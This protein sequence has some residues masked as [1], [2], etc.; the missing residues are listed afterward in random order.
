MNEENN[1]AEATN[2][3][4][5]LTQSGLKP[6]IVPWE[7]YRGL[8]TKITVQLKNVEEF[9]KEFDEAGAVVKSRDERNN[10]YTPLK[11]VEDALTKWETYLEQHGAHQ[12][13]MKKQNKDYVDEEFTKQLAAYQTND[14][15][16]NYFFIKL[17]RLCSQ[18]NEAQQEFRQRLG[19]A[20]R[21]EPE[22][23]TQQRQIVVVQDD[24]TRLNHGLR[25]D[26]LSDNA[27]V[28]QFEGWKRD[29]KS[30]FTINAMDKKSTDVQISALY[31][32]LDE[33]L[34]RY[35]DIHFAAL[36]SV[37]IV[38]DEPHS[39]LQALIHYFDSKHP[40]P[41]RVLNFFNERQRPNES[42]AEFA[43]RCEALA[44]SANIEKMTPDCW[45][46]H[47]IATGLVHSEQLRNKLL[48]KLTNPKYKSYD[49][50]KDIEEETAT[51]KVT[52]AIDRQVNASQVNQLSDYKRQI[53]SNRSNNYQKQQWQSGGLQPRIPS[54]P[55]PRLSNA[56]PPWMRPTSRACHQC[57]YTPFFECREHFR[58]RPRTPAPFQSRG[59]PNI[60]TLREAEEDEEGESQFSNTLNTVTNIP[61]ACAA[62]TA[63]FERNE[64]GNPIMPTGKQ[65]PLLYAFIREK[66]SHESLPS[67]PNSHVTEVLCLAD[68]GCVRS[69]CHPSM[70][71]KCGLRINHND[72]TKM[73]AANGTR[74]N[75]IG[76]VTAQVSY[77]GIHTDLKIFIMQDVSPNYIILDREVCQVLNIFH[78]DFPLPL[79]TIPQ[80]KTESEPFGGKFRENSH[81]QLTLDNRDMNLS[82]RKEPKSEEKVSTEKT[83][84]NES[85]C[86][87]SETKV[88]IT[89]SFNDKS[90]EDE[91]LNKLNKLIECY[92]PVFDI[93]I[94]KEIKCH[95]VRLRFRQD[96]P[97]T[98]YK[99]TSSRP[100]PFALREAARKEVEEQIKLGIIARVPPNVHLEWCSRGMV[101]AKDNARDCRIVCDNVELNK[102]LDRNAFPIQSP[103]ELVKQ[104]PTT[105]K[106]FLSCDFYKGFFQIP[107]AVEDQHK[108]AFMLHSIGILYYKR[109]MQG[110]KTSVDEFNRITDELVQEV[111]NCLKMVDD[112]L[113]HGPTIDDVLTQFKCLLEKCHQRNFT[114]HPKKLKF[115]NRL[116]FAGYRV[117]DKGL[118]IDPKKVNAI[119]KFSKP[120][121]VTDMKSFLGLAAQFQEACPDLLGILKPLSDATSF[122]ITPGF[123]E[124]GKKIKNHKRAIVWSKP[125]EEAFVKAKQALTDADGRVLAP[126][127]PALPLIIYTDAS[128]L[129]GLGWVALQEREGIKR[130]V[131]CGSA[132]IS[133]AMRR[134][135]SVSELEL[136]AVLT[137]LRKMRLL[138]VGNP[139]VIVRTDHLPLIGILKKPLDKIET[140]RLM[141]MA[142]KLQSYSF[143]I[144]YV[145]GTKNE[146]ADALSRYPIKSSQEENDIENEIA[147]N[148]IN[149]YEG[150]KLSIK[151]LEKIAESDHH[152][153]EIRH[154][155]LNNVRSQDLPPD[156]PG[157]LHRSNWHLLATHGNLITLGQRILIPKAARKE[158]LKMLH[159]AHLG[160]TKTI[161]LAKQMYFWKG[162]SSEIKQLIDACEQCQTHANFQQ[163]ETLM[164]THATYPMEQNSADFAEYA[165][166][167]YLIHVDRFSGYMWIYKMPR[168]TTQGTI[169]AMWQTFYQFGFPK[170]LRTDNGGQFV[171]DAFILACRK[172]NIEQEWSSPFHSISNGFCEKYVGIAKNLIKKGANFEEIQR[173]LQLY[174]N[175][176][177]T[178][179]RSP[180]ELFFGRKLRTNLPT[181]EENFN[182]LTKEKVDE[183]II[184]RK[185]LYDKRQIEYNKSARDLTPL[186]INQPV[187]IYNS[188]TSEWDTKGIVKFCDKTCGRSYRIETQNGNLIWRNR[189]YLKPIKVYRQPTYNR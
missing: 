156:H 45:I 183:A 123:D 182:P 37:N 66:K 184:K 98:P 158:I 179:T 127:D 116:I 4:P 177:N 20:D 14:Q 136:N 16:Y 56:R 41:L 180:S 163:K 28:L 81:N 131:E 58:P 82:E 114:L 6:R 97:I 107:L 43:Q 13:W 148:E 155:I 87:N 12:A 111:P 29:I 101:L 186:R 142:E 9:V 51:D 48:K 176:P 3:G 169:Q 181:L 1:A 118:E 151:E 154:A 188:T 187:R 46:K 168:A 52:N 145:K 133:E 86:N 50:K 15:R 59:R 5:P 44:I 77:F 85:D 80:Q 21:E 128:R 96:I 130:L 92:L 121:N 160:Q 124:K 33:K 140:R 30:Y 115:G 79:R 26:K 108:T 8:K 27:T 144:E 139:N 132:T 106:F 137:S 152:Y 141:K 138:T 122:K 167:R 135:F 57:G 32:C 18:Y 11:K 166:K 170:K 49:L 146:L 120:N 100:I 54:Q 174:N 7:W 178:S 23:Y 88:V 69:V 75:C 40:K 113:F 185:E 172:D 119:R 89:S 90:E 102:F 164:P 63:N 22:R 95:P 76:S 2:E 70:A 175:T 162:M 110:G 39:Y 72:I 91:G 64:F 189:R 55:R 149:E 157:R 34:K 99:C 74:L 73:Y 150:E 161:A 173:M 105:S 10:L 125:L 65:T 109:V 24:E 68:S 17:N 35:L 134:N 153:T 53:T 42:P 25:P 67:L 171:S 38:S 93:S 83:P 78:K 117:S 159:F 112:I 36:P 62:M 129:Q 147:L 84:R 104:I 31:A 60:Q 165:S 94:K 71:R 19:N 103:R 126:F 61:N 47:K 143:Q